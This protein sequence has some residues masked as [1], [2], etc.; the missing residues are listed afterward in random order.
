MILSK[1]Q[2]RAVDHALGTARN[3]HPPRSDVIAA[4]RILRQTF[5][6]IA[7][8]VDQEDYAADLCEMIAALEPLCRDDSAT[9]IEARSA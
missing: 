6:D 3:S 9:R 8:D 5:R 2:T 4:L 7:S 1:E